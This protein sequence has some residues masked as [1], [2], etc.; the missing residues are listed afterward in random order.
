MTC[1]HRIALLISS[2]ALLAC[3]APGSGSDDASDAGET[4]SDPPTAAACD[5]AD[6][7][8]SPV[9]APELLVRLAD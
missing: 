1:P 8:G 9:A 5:P 4:G 2:I 3:A 6:P 7:D